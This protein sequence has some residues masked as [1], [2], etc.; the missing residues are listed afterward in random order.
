HWRELPPFDPAPALPDIATPLAGLVSA[1]PALAR[2]LSQIG[3]VEDDALG[4]ICQPQL[5]PGQALVSRSGAVWRWDGYTIRPGTPTAATGRLQQRNRLAVRQQELVSATAEADQAR[6]A[7]DAAESDDRA[8]TAADQHARAIRT[9]AERHLERARSAHE[10]LRAE[11][12]AH[13]A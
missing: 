12:S 8:A 3:V 11:V 10:S 13:S 2:A 9:E 1:P 5:A 6:E 4:D 7:R